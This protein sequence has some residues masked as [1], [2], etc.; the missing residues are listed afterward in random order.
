M[1]E[2]EEFFALIIFSLI[3]IFYLQF[4]DSVSWSLWAAE[5]LFLCYFLVINL[6]CQCFF[7]CSIL[8]LIEATNSCYFTIWNS[9]MLWMCCRFIKHNFY[10]FLIWWTIFK[11]KCR[12][13]T[14]SVTQVIDSSAASQ[15]VP[16]TLEIINF[17]M[18]QYIW[19]PVRIVAYIFSYMGVC[20]SMTAK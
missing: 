12:T 7:N 14:I 11:C 18:Q 10:I 5:I 20:F 6:W 3:L 19:Y 9:N 17:T 1:K 15:C 8:L 16:N 4:F 13:V 2:Q